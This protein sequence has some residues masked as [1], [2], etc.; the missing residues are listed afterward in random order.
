MNKLLLPIACFAI[1][2][3]CLAASLPRSPQGGM[4]AAPPLDPH[5]EPVRHVTAAEAAAVIERPGVVVLD[6]RTPS[7][8]AAAHIAGARLVDFRSP[9]FRDELAR[10]D[11][12]PHY[13]VYC[14]SGNRSTHALEVFRELEFQ[15]VT[16][17]D[18]G[19]LAWS[20]AGLPVQ[21]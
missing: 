20:E 7:E 16:H 12:A 13:V 6:V 2:G 1:L 5:P 4:C 17:L 15:S 18:G 3:L 11:R 10:L 14:R 8:Y 19:I 21:R 9:G